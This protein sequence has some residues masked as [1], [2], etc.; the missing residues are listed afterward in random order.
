MG[1]PRVKRGTH[2]LELPPGNHIVAGAFSEFEHAEDF[3]DTMFERGFHDT[4]LGYQSEKGY[5][6]VV[7]FRSDDHSKAATQR[8]RIRKS[9]GM[10]KV[11][12]LTVE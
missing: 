3:S 4:I 6:Y 9:P 12:I 2:Y 1:A 11:W 5:Y 10:E 7:I 8:S